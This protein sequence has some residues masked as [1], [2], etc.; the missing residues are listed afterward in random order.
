ML[1]FSPGQALLTLLATLLLL[2]EIACVSALGVCKEHV[3][4][5]LDFHTAVTEL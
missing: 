2:L 4:R 1:L 3:L 5:W